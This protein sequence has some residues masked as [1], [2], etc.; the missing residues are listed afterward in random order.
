VTNSPATPLDELQAEYWAI[1][2]EIREF[3]D[4]AIDRRAKRAVVLAAIARLTS[5]KKAADLTGLTQQRIGQLV[6]GVRE[7]EH[8]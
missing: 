8:D 2:A 7:S 4:K 1:D 6:K 3:I 5:Q